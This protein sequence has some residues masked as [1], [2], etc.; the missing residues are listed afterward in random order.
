VVLTPVTA[1]TCRAWWSRVHHRHASGHLDRD[2]GGPA[3]PVLAPGTCARTGAAED[4]SG[5][6]SGP[7]DRPDLIGL[8]R[9]RSRRWPCGRAVGGRSAVSPRGG[10]DFAPS[11]WRSVASHGQVFDL[12]SGR[13]GHR[14]R[15]RRGPTGAAPAGPDVAFDTTLHLT[16]AA[17]ARLAVPGAL[18]RAAARWCQQVGRCRHPGPGREDEA[19]SPRGAPRAGARRS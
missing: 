1:P 3:A 4:A 17:L 6:H 2:R 13:L 12:V 9:L 14:W 8:D 5:T 11:W 18:R 16:P 15:R 10:G 7:G 19:S